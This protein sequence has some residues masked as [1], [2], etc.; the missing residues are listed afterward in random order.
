MPSRKRKAIKKPPKGEQLTPMPEDRLPWY[1]APLRATANSLES[2]LRLFQR[3]KK[4]TVVSPPHPARRR[5][6][7]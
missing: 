7:K 1:Y 4:W 2:V 6:K 5:R 3:Q